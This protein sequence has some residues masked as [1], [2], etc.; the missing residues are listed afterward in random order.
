LKRTPEILK[1]LEK[2]IIVSLESALPDATARGQGILYKG[3]TAVSLVNPRQSPSHVEPPDSVVS[4][5]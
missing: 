2:R 1:G 3:G 5:L 4:W